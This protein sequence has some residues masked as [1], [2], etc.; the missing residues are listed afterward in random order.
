[1]PTLNLNINVPTQAEIDDFCAA[2]GYTGQGTKAAFVKSV[3]INMVKSAIKSYRTGQVRVQTDAT[4]KAVED[5]VTN[6]DIS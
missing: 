3:L 5:A 4:L 2:Y 6:L 1:M